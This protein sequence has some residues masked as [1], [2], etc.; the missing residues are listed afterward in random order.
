MENLP[1]TKCLILVLTYIKE[2]I[3]KYILRAFKVAEDLRNNYNTYRV[4]FSYRPLLQNS[5]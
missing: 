2:M 3:K 1:E 5:W 4:F